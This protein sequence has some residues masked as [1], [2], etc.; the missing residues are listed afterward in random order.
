[1]SLPRLT[2]GVA[3]LL[4]MVVA[5]AAP[6]SANSTT[7]YKNPVVGTFAD[8]CTGETVALSGTVVNVIS[9][10]TNGGISHLSGEQA[11]QGVSAVGASGTKYRLINS[12]TG[13]E[14]SETYSPTGSVVVHETQEFMVV[15]Q[16]PLDNY[17]LR[18]SLLIV[19]SAG[20]LDVSKQTFTSECI[21]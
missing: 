1:V 5:V 18:T 21:G 4:I 9:Q 17:V 20:K 19:G 12:S 8:P 6:A 10:F 16:G 7:V 13:G 3:A 15:S 11:W 14:I 2:V